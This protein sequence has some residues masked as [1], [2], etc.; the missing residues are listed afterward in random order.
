MGVLG[1]GQTGKVRTELEGCLL[2]ASGF[3]TPLGVP[4]GA[5][6]CPVIGVRSVAGEGL[7]S[8]LLAGSHGSNDRKFRP[9]CVL[10]NCTTSSS[11]VT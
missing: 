5:P 4:R 7:T 8:S 11:T 9:V 10:I 6:S 3:E 1:G 2:T